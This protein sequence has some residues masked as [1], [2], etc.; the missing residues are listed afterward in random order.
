MASLMVLNAFVCVAVH[1][2]S[3]SFFIRPCR[4]DLRLDK[5]WMNLPRKLTA[6]RKLCKSFTFCGIGQFLIDSTL[7]GSG[8]IPLSVSMLP[9]NGTLVHLNLNFF[10]FKVKLTSKA[11]FSR[12][13][14][15]LSCSSTVLP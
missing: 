2:Y 3:A 7:V 10:G 1:T 12:A 8:F 13:N 9:K 14:R 4:L 5:P 11:L 6:P 15:F